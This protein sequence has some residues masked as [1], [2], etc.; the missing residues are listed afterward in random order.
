MAIQQPPPQH[1]SINFVPGSPINLRTSAA[2]CEMS[3]VLA[4]RRRATI[5][6]GSRS[7]AGSEEEEEN[8][9]EGADDRGE[10]G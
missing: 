3:F 6:I 9:R 5:S 8:V 7:S 10:V 1:F 2:F 4:L